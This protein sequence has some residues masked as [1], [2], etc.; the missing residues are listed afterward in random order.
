MPGREPVWLTI[1]TLHALHANLIREYGGSTGVRDE[2]LLESALARPQNRWHYGERSLGALAAAYLSGLVRNHA[3]VDGDKRIAAAAAGV[4]LLLNGKE[5][6]APE[7][8]LVEAVLA[9]ITGE[10][11]EEVLAGWI[12]GHLH[13]LQEGEASPNESNE[14]EEEVEEEKEKD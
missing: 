5:L 4:F 2:G 3:Y 6:D 8:E 11:T 12:E 13:P 7:P 9:V 1:R 10:W 14:E